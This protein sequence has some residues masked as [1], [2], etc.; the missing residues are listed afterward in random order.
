VA[1]SASGGNK[2]RLLTGG[3]GSLDGGGVTNVL[4]V[5]T[6]VGVLHGVTG[7][8]SDD[9]PVLALGLGGVVGGTGLQQ[10]LLGTA[11][12]GDDADH[13]TAVPGE[14]LLLTG[15]EL[16]AGLLLLG[17]VGDDDA[18]LTRGTGDGATVTGLQLNVADDGTLGNHLEG[19]AV[20]DSE[21]GLL[22]A[23]QELAGGHALN[24]D[25]AGLNTLELVGVTE[26]DKGEGSTTAGVVDNL[27]DGTLDETASLTEVKRSELGS[28]L[29]LVSV[30][31][32]DAAGTT[33]LGQNRLSHCV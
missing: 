4:M 29:T 32:E 21:L 12:T 22:T 7:A 3:A 27:T 1:T 17:K 33:S 16:D 31:S 10:R 23:V 25:H 19:K 20:T 6:T 5:T 14:G 30:G 18:V 8:T 15:G 28:S 26:L 2:T 13:G 11:T 9:G 24:S